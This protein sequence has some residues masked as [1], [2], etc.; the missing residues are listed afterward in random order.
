MK[1]Y[2]ANDVVQALSAIKA[3]SALSPLLLTEIFDSFEEAVIVA[4][5]NRHMIYVNTA[6]EHLF[7]Y[8]QGAML[9][10]KTQIL[11]AD[12]N[13]F[14]EQGKKRFNAKSIASSESY[15]VVYR[16]ADGEQFL[17]ITTGAPMRSVDGTVIG[18]I[19]I[20]RPARSA[21]QSLNTL[22]QVH[23]ITSDVD[24]SHDQKI[25]HLLRVG[26][27]H[28]GL[29]IAIISRITGNKYT[30][31]NCVDFHENL[32][33]STT[34]DLLGTYCIHTLT[35]NKTVG[36][37]FVSNSEIRDHPCYQNFKL[38]S[39]IGT[40]IRLNESIYGTINFSSTL[41]VEPFCKDDYILMELLSDTFSYLLYKKT[42]E[43]EMES[44]AKTD[45]LT[46]LP[47][48]RATLERLNELIE[49]SNRFGYNLSVLSIDID[50]FKQINDKWG[51]AIGDKALVHFAQIASGLGRKT[52]FCGR[53]G[54]EEF[55]FVLSGANLM[56]CQEFGDKLRHNLT[57]EPFYLD[58]GESIT[59]S[60][61][62]GVAMLM[63]HEPIEELL[64][65]ADDAMY[66][67]KSLGR[68]CVSQ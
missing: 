3:A 67:A 9:G 52:D 31:E 48:R 30:V 35:E 7:G 41:P 16:R 47:N 45:E 20:I 8:P 43:E 2:K 25:D 1:E 19:G 59:V 61:S 10:E 54:G 22:R 50:L 42:S 17:G 49:Q 53:M 11:Y 36:F 51:H 24:L 68:N 4:D 33:A 57:A 60:I 29:E 5:A 44:L 14:S 26:L 6:A 39:Y 32:E 64:A 15:R 63:N 55:I 13:D 56:D 46:G 65:R 38:E 28:F 27:D 62:A 58:T 40:P 66:K 37:H 34:F 18:F 12:E 23:N 21:D